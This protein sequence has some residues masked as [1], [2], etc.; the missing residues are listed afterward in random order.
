MNFE[1]FVDNTCLYRNS[2]YFYSNFLRNR[3]RI[4]EFLANQN[5]HLLEASKESA[6]PDAIFS[7]NV[8]LLPYF[9]PKTPKRVVLNSFIF[10]NRIQAL[11][12]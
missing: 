2:Y 9:V 10:K 4:E 6:L 1:L 5:L 7:L 3:Y 12:F 11:I 8:S